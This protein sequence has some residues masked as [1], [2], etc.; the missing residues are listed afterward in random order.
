[1]AHCKKGAHPVRTAQEMR[2]LSKTKT[3]AEMKILAWDFW[4]D[5]CGTS[6]NVQRKCVTCKAKSHVS[7]LADN[8]QCYP[9]FKGGELGE[10]L[11]Q[12]YFQTPQGAATA[13]TPIESHYQTRT[14]D[15]NPNGPKI[16]DPKCACGVRAELA[17][18]TCSTGETPAS[19]TF[20][21]LTHFKDLG[22]LPR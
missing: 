16:A 2:E 22:W 6:Y 9:C 19:I 13:T 3:I 14:D 1:M 21:C 17:A 7:G 10:I 12:N 18:T 4:A 20:Y 5:G 8:G 15:G 11:R